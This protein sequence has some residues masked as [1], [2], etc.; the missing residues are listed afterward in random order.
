ML[1][2]S[3]TKINFK[4][5]PAHIEQ[6]H[7]GPKD[8]EDGTVTYLGKIYSSRQQLPDEQV[9]GVSIKT[10]KGNGWSRVGYEVLIL[11]DGTVHRFVEDNGDGFIDSYETT[12]GAGGTNAYTKHICLEGGMGSTGDVENNFTPE[13]WHTLSIFILEELIKHP[14]LKLIGHNQKNS[15]KACPSFDVRKWAKSIAISD[16]NI[17]L[18]SYEKNPFLQES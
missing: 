2:C 4:L 15:Y 11:R 16:K 9:G 14:E 18:N 12:F 6:W 7:L 5:T 1:H 10:L 3:W 8:N 13:Q 17:D